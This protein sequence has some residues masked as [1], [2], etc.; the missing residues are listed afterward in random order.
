MDS[1]N[2]WCDNDP[3]SIVTGPEHTAEISDE[4]ATTTSAAPIAPRGW[5]AD[6]TTSS[7]TS[8]PNLAE[9]AAVLD[10][11]G[12]MKAIE[13][14]DGGWNGGDT[15][16][17]LCQWFREFG[18]DVDADWVAAAQ[19]LSL[20]PWLAQYVN[21]QMLDASN[22]VIHLHSDNTSHTDLISAHLTNLVR[23]LGEGSTAAVYD[24]P[25]ERII[26]IAH[27]ELTPPLL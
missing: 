12:R 8:A 20:P 10:L 16:D 24:Q 7:T 4:S 3:E 22:L 23:A 13:D 19:A 1:E 5:Q 21:S 27:A 11:F 9:C 6:P 25:G 14:E 18:I 26:R 15:V 2:T 17:E